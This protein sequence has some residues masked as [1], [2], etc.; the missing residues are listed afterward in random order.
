MLLNIEEQD[1][2]HRL[3]EVLEDIEPGTLF[4]VIFKLSFDD[5]HEN[6]VPRE[7]TVGIIDVIEDYKKASDSIVYIEQLTFGSHGSVPVLSLRKRRELAELITRPPDPDADVPISIW[8]GKDEW[9]RI[10]TMLCMAGL[11]EALIRMTMRSK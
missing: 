7:K 10:D 5:V 4:H 3:N 8:V 9:S 2:Y 1:F 6:G 11:P